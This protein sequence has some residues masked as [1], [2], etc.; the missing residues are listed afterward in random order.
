M[1]EKVKESLH[2]MFEISINDPPWCEKTGTRILDFL[3]VD[4]CFFKPRE[5]DIG[6]PQKMLISD[7]NYRKQIQLRYDP[8]GKV[9]SKQVPI[10]ERLNNIE[11]DDSFLHIKQQYS[12]SYQ[13]AV[14]TCGIDIMHAVC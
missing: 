7:W 10:A 14:S 9:K 6:K 13:Y 5:E 11:K 2:S 4:L 12:G 3:H 8:E 1:L